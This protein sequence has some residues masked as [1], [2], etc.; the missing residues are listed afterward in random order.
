MARDRLLVLSYVL[1]FP[2]T[3][4]Q[5]QRVSYTLQAA[6]KQF[7]VTFATSVAPAKEREVREKL[8]ALCDDV[9][10]LPSRYP[11]HVAGRAWHKA[12]GTLRSLTTGLKYSNYI[13]G[14]LEFPP[15][16]VASMLNGHKFDCVLFEY[17]HAAESTSVFRRIGTPCLLDM[18]NIL[19]QDYARDVNASPRA[20]EF[21]KS[22]AIRR[23]REHEE[24]AWKKFDGLITINREEHDYVQR[25]NAGSSSLFYAPMGTDLSLWPYSW[26]PV[27]PI[28]LAYYGGLGSKHN[29]LDALRCYEKI[30]P[31][32]WRSFPDAELWLIGSNPPQSLRTLAS[33]PRV[34]VTG[35]IK[36]VQKLLSTMS[37]VLCP[38]TG[39][40]GFRS[41]LIEVM[42]LGVPLV[43]SSDAIYGMELEH[44][45]DLLLGETDHDLASHALRL[46]NDEQSAVKQSQQARRNVERLY[47]LNSTYDRLIAELSDWLETNRRKVA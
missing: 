34:K 18:H 19:W 28:R 13:I 46:L 35:F 31:E 17:W 37:V 12:V 6:R 45:T 26:T 25:Q 11:R 21:W 41:R 20:P 32:I 47:S 40:Y 1:P 2:G 15:D 3:S 42:A 16:R 7:H 23:Y 24:H 39:T 29:Q 44:G 43:A 27:Q 30:M 33:N 36:D 38:W 14:E 5:Q 10:L 9:L 4:G 22:R 8:L